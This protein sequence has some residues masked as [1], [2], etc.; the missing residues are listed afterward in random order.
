MDGGSPTRFALRMDQALLVNLTPRQ[1][2][3]LAC[4]VDGKSSKDIS[5][6]LGIAPNTVRREESV[7]HDE[8]IKL[9]GPSV[10]ESLI[11]E[12]LSEVEYELPQDSVELAST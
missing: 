8:H 7:I 10:L 6:L 9:F 4:L 3:I 5:A 2:Q 11:R 12:K 1:R